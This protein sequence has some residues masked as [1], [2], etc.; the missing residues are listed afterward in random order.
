MPPLNEQE[1][2]RAEFS[3]GTRIR[4]GDGQEWTFPKPWL[5]IFPRRGNDGKIGLGGGSGWGAEYTE[6]LDAYSETGDEDYIER[7][8][9]QVRMAC[10]LLCKNYDL[11]DRQLES[12]LPW[13]PS[14][15]AN[16]AMWRD[17]IG[18]LIL[19]LAPKPSADGSATPSSPTV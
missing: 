6:L 3:D 17:E 14:D 18:P 15:E 10:M 12:L 9:L 16:S 2:R 8:T 4:L 7:L 19:G 11:T 1:L 13:E 5:R